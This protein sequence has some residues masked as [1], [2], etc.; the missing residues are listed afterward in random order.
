MAKKKPYRFVLYLAARV[1]AAALN[2][3]P[4]QAALSL[5]RWGGWMAYRLV[6]RQ[7]E[8]ILKNLRFAFGSSKSEQEIQV[9]G[10]KVLEHFAETGIEILRFPTLTP[11][12][13]PKFV[14]MGNVIEVYR[15]L[16]AAGRGLIS[17]TAHLGNW[18][19]LA[20]AVVSHG[21]ETAVV[22]RRIYYKPYDR[23]VVDLRQALG[24]RTIYRDNSAR[25]L[26]TFLKNN[27]VVGMLP[28]QDV[29]GLSGVFVDFLGHPAYTP[30]APVKLSLA[31]GAPILTNFLVRE[32]GD[33]YRV[34]LGEIIRPQ[35]ETTR[36][37]A[38]QKY[39][40]AWMKE[41]EKVVCQYPEQWAWMHDR[42]KTTPEQRQSVRGAVLKAS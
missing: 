2:G 31:S 18:E 13:I 41:F 6:P 25:Q 19:L 12:A 5:A 1:V 40:E 24:V 37:E 34:I 36:E 22:A 33:R 16:L 27:G 30:V 21:V 32:T 3:L 23:W 39:T 28:D 26:L 35:I 15:S 17:I 11:A 7:R 14:D 10:R 8:A 20:G 38:V 9:L 29:E 42:W 4:R